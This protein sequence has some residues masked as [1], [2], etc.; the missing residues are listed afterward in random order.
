MA[1]RR[2]L[3]PQRCRAQE[4]GKRTWSTSSGLGSPSGGRPDVDGASGVPLVGGA[5]PAAAG[6]AGNASEASSG[7]LRPGA[8]RPGGRSPPRRPRAAPPHLVLMLLWKPPS[9]RPC[10]AAP[11]PLPR[12]RATAI[13]ARGSP[14][15]RSCCTASPVASAATPGMMPLPV[16]CWT[17]GPA[18]GRLLLDAPTCVRPAPSS[19]SLAASCCRLSKP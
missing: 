6:P 16:T 2:A 11:A 13:A 18:S 12:W 10:C 1:T 3:H 19:G 15:L 7:A 17:A 14:G 9:W 8:L 5:A 4:A